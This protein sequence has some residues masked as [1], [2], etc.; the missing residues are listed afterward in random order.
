MKEFK[1]HQKYLDKAAL[2]GI[3]LT[4]TSKEYDAFIEKYAETSEAL[5]KNIEKGKEVAPE[6]IN[7]L[8]RA[9][10]EAISAEAARVS[11]KEAVEPGKVV[12][13]PGKP[14]PKAEPLPGSKAPKVENIAAIPELVTQPFSVPS[15]SATF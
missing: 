7:E 13:E 14:L 6:R 1:P 8:E 11:V 10:Q 15:M 3:T 4:A 12:A 5:L 9:R 2:L